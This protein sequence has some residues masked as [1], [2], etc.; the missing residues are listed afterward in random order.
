MRDALATVI[1]GHNVIPS[2]ARNLHCV[3]LDLTPISPI[4]IASSISQTRFL[5]PLGMTV[6]CYDTQYAIPW[7][8]AC[9]NERPFAYGV[10]RKCGTAAFISKRRV[11]Q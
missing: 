6:C 11:I 7:H 2:G 3:T 9:Y 10:V 4:T 8:V 1:L 5:A